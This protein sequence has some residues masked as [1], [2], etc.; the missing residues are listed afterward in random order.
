MRQT[1]KIV[2]GLALI[3]AGVIWIL[4]IIGILSFGFSTKGW[5]ALFII[6][7]CLVGFFNDRGDRV[8]PL[9][10]VGVGVLLLLAARDVITW[11]MMWQI[12]L[13]LM[14]IGF[15]IQLLLFKNF[16][17]C[18]HHGSCDHKTILSDGKNIHRI[19]SSFGKQEVSFAGEKFEG[20]E[21]HTSFGGMELN[22]NGAEIAPEAFIK[23]NVGFSGVSIIVPE[24]LA[25]QVNVSS[26]FGGV[27]DKRT[28][29]VTTG[30]PLL[31]IT[32]EVGFGG[33]EI[34]N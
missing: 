23:L 29:K 18:G 6:I 9:V 21:V 1:G 19:D 28:N 20:A 12:A 4:N 26:G 11:K 3:A 7:P 31:I 22:L 25:V 16:S 10:G 34:H 14:I 13:A 24:G 8:G 33:V 17:C 2:F 32:G 15:G 27:A 5:W 30:S